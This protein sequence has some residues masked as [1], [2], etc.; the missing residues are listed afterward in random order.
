[1]TWLYIL[2]A[3]FVLLFILLFSSVKVTAKYEEA[4]SLKVSYL[5]LKFDIPSEKKKEKEEKPKEKKEAK[6]G[7]SFF[8]KHGA[9]GLIEILTEVLR[10]VNKHFKKLSHLIIS[11]LSVDIVAGDN[12]AASVAL[13]YGKLC[14][15]VYP[16]VSGILGIIKHKKY[17]VSVTPDFNLKK[18]KASA[19]A[20][21]SMK[22]I[23]LLNLLLGLGVDGIKLYLNI[24]KGKYYKKEDGAENDRTSY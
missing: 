8:K 10:F 2:I 3:I 5:F 4:L 12:D 6:K 21:L 7:D 22:L 23:F 20:V 13:T 14:G 1:M 11:D 9:S 18:T 24:R 19:Y 17:K 16:I 15:V